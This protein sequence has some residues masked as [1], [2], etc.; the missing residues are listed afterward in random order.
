MR[1]VGLLC[2]LAMVA[3]G[4]VD[5]QPLVGGGGAEGTSGGGSLGGQPPAGAAGSASPLGGAGSAAAGSAAVSG[6]GTSGG[7]APGSAGNAGNAGNAGSAGEAGSAGACAESSTELSEWPG[8]STVVTLDAEGDFTSDLS[9]LTY[10]SPGVLWAVNN[11]SAKLFRLVKRGSGYELDPANGWAAGKSLRFREGQGIPD[12][13]GVTLAASSASGVYVGSERDTNQAQASRLSVLRYDVS[14]AG[15]TLDATHEWD[16]TAALP[17]VGANTG[18]EAVTWV[19]DAWLT[20]HAFF[21][22]SRGRPYAPND[23][24]DHGGGVFLVGLEQT[25]TVY[26]FALNHTSGAATLLARI[27]TPLEGVMGLEMDRDS[28]E[29]WAHCDDTCDNQAAVLALAP[30]GR[31]ELKRWVRSPSGLPGSNHEGIALA[32]DSECSGGLKPFFWTDDADLDGF[33]L[34]QGALSCGCR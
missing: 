15:S 10:E 11:L 4:Q 32:P 7:A 14:E 5:A 26:G 34:R 3:C 21:D 23:Y 16:L 24:G 29:L 2:W 1:R 8:A 30:S 12:A 9:G 22:E 31:F 27:S 18:L 25:D 17:A 6:A 20:A 13:E 28:G 33:S 19:S